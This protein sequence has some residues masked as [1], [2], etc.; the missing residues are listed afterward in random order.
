MCAKH[1]I[2]DDRGSILLLGPRYSGIFQSCP[3][4][5]SSIF[6]PT[7]FLLW[8]FSFCPLLTLAITLLWQFLI[9]S[10]F[11][12][13]LFTLASFYSGIFHP[14]HF[15][16]WHPLY[17]STFHPTHFSLWHFS[18]W[19]FSSCLHFTLAPTLL[20]HFSFCPHLTLTSIRFTPALFI[21]PVFYSVA[22]TTSNNSR[23]RNTKLGRRRT[24]IRQ[25]HDLEQGFFHQSY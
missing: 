14:A 18:L 6:H 20:W 8:H 19:H 21:L 25:F 9:Y 2:C 17:S 11:T 23:H 22:A 4:F 1:V 10:L 7:H 16:L 5:Y 15:S 12:L 3:L 13:A 24:Q